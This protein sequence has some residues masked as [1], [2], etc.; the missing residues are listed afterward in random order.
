M[1]ESDHLSDCTGWINLVFVERERTLRKIIKKGIRHH[2]AEL[3][4]SNTV[5]LLEELGVDRS[6]ITH[7]VEDALFL[8]NDADDLIGG[9]LRENYSY[10]AEQHGFKNS[11]ERVFREVQQQIPSFSNCFNHV[12][13]PT[14]ETWLQAHAVW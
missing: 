12:D 10:R 1:S 2:L 14:S 4:L 8:V 7:D 6:R 5:I 13:P 11:V 3:L 9:L